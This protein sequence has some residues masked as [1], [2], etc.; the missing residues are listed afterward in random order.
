MK[1]WKK[2]S[3]MSKM[4]SNEFAP[5]DDQ[6]SKVPFRGFRG[7]TRWQSYKAATRNPVKALRYE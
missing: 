7:D 3:F 6:S 2:I 5:N 4:K 1:K